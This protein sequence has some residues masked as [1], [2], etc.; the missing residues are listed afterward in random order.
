M[1]VMLAICLSL[2]PPT[3]HGLVLISVIGV[4]HCM[5]EYGYDHGLKYTVEFTRSIWNIVLSA[6][7]YKVVL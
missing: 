6:Y 3:S 5:T 2:S 1:E 7:G 4:Y